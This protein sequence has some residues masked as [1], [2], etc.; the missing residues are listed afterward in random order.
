[1]QARPCVP[2][3][4]GEVDELEEYGLPPVE[5]VPVDLVPYVYLGGE[6]EEDGAAE[7]GDHDQGLHADGELGVAPLIPGAE[8]QGGGVEQVQQGVG[9]DHPVDDR[10]LA[11][12]GDL[13]VPDRVQVHAGD[14]V[15]GEVRDRHQQ[16]SEDEHLEGEPSPTGPVPA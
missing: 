8:D 10:E 11:V 7:R 4:V 13:R 14:V 5:G 1:M 9:E 2:G 12:Q 6:Q 3:V 15:G 16:E